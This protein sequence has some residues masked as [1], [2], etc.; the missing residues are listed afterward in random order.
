MRIIIDTNVL[1]SAFVFSGKVEKLLEMLFDGGYELLVSDYVDAEFKA[2]LEEKWPLKAQK[3]YSLYRTL[4]F[5]F[6]P[7]TDIKKGTLRDPKDIPVLSDALFYHADLILTGDKDFLAANL[8][9]PLVFSP[10]ML[11]DYLIRQ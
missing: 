11:Y 9:S 1:I 4:P 10:V 3:V 6:C 8:E 2:K 5:K 7:S